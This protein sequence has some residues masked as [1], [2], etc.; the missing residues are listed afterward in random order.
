[1]IE[2]RSLLVGLAAL[3]TAPAIV[4]AGSIMPVNS[5]LVSK[6]T[7]DELVQWR[8]DQAGAAMERQLA[9]A[10]MYGSGNSQMSVDQITREA[11]R[12]FKNSNS[13]IQGLDA[14]YALDYKFMDGE[15]WPA[16]FARDGAKI[17]DTL[18][19]RLPSDYIM[20]DGPGLSVQDVTERWLEYD[21]PTRTIVQRQRAINSVPSIPTPL[22][23]AALAVA[24]APL[25]EQA[26][27]KPVTRRFWSK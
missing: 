24:A 20:S 11:V 7:M 2:R 13:F 12:L 14:Q 5:K 25:V 18:M 15:Q 6:M 9:D 27:Q 8:I 19:I 4:K 22:A 26:L 17:G 3:I 21:K 16:E 1:M 23:V 10:V